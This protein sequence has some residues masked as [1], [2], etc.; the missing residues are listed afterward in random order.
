MYIYVKNIINIGVN[1][2]FY[3][4]NNCKKNPNKTQNNYKISFLIEKC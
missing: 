2:Y 4:K 3:I 1:T